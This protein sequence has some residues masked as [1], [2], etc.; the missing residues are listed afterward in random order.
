MLAKLTFLVPFPLILAVAGLFLWF[1]GG[2][3]PMPQ[4][5]AAM[6]DAM[7]KPGPEHKALQK[8]VGI[9][10]AKVTMHMP[11]TPPQ[12][13]KATET[14]TAFGPFWIHSD[15]KGEMMGQP[16]EGR[17]TQTYDPHKKV[18]VGT[19]HD[20]MSPYNMVHEGTYDEKTRTL[21]CKSS[22]PDMMNPAK[23]VKM[24]MTTV[25][26]NDNER[27]FSMYEEH[28]GKEVLGMVVEY[29][30]RK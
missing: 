26:K 25:W 11:G 15:F 9:W 16:F 8:D 22:M 21:T 27:T 28:D 12:E 4:D 5:A 18:Y 6:M 19:W 1:Q 13:S 7:P 20:T 30:R 3:H 17:G 14:V 29:K 10:D 23:I 2:E 24:R